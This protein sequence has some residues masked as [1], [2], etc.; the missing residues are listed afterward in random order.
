MKKDNSNQQKKAVKASKSASNPTD[1]KVTENSKS[2]NGTGKKQK[3]NSSALI[4]A[5]KGRSA[6]DSVKSSSNRDVR[7][8]SGLSNTGPFVSYE[9]K[10]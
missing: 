1:N 6:V 5:S 4:A 3:K 10:E 9:N 7:G 8:S 2:G